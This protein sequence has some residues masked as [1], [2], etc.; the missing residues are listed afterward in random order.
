MNSGVSSEVRKVTSLF[1]GLAPQF[2]RGREI[3]RIQNLAAKRRAAAGLSDIQI[4]PRSGRAAQ[5]AV[6]KIQFGGAQFRRDLA[7]KGIEIFPQLSRSR[8]N[9]AGFF[10]CSSC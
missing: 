3:E 5:A 2:G 9:E 7:A 6:E 4:Q 10:I 8:S 1:F